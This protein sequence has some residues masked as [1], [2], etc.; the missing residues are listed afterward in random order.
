[1]G[2][3]GRLLNMHLI[4]NKKARFDYDFHQTIEAGIELMGTEVKAIKNGI[5]SLVGARV[6]IRGGEAY[7]LGATIPPYQAKNAPAGYDPDRTRRLLLSKKELRT[8]ATIEKGL[9]VVP[10]YCY[11][12]G[13]LIKLAFG[14]GRKRK[15]YDKREVLKERTDDRE[16]ARSLKT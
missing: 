13:K 10:M 15:A 3:N 16:L 4:E 11:T 14:I 6:I 5:G 8:L 12:K 2:Q 7:L 9:T 1:M